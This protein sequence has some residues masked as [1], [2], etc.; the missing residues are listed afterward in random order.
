MLQELG[1]SD[2]VGIVGALVIAWAYFAATRGQLPARGAAFNLLNLLG[3][4]LILVSLWVRP[5]IG[6]IVIE[7]LWALIALGALVRSWRQQR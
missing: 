1:W 5:N 3:A 7:L 4:G 6:A 2:A